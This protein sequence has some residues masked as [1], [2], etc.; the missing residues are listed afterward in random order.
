MTEHT[1]KAAGVNLDAAQDI[2]QRIGAIVTPTHGPEVLGGIGAFGAMYQLSGYK[3]PVLV[4]GTDGVGTKL[5]LAVMMDRYDTIGEDLVNA[6][7]NDVIVSGAKPL[8]FLDYIAVGELSPNVIEALLEGMARACREV[9]CALIGGETAQMP[10]LYAKDDFDM[11]GFVV[12][13]VEKSAM[14][15]SSSIREGDVLLGILSNGLHT[16]GYSLV[17]HTLGLD[18][19]P[20]PLWEHHP[21]LGQTLGDAL[22]TP[23]R[24]YYR[25]VR[26]A[27]SLV[28]GM[29][30]ITGGGLIEN[31]PRVLPEGLAARFDADTWK[32]P[33][34]FTVLQEMSDI[35]RDEMYRV[36]NMG[37]GMVLVCERSKADEV[38]ALVPE[39]RV[40]GEVTRVT[41]ERRVIL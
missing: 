5:K 31:V 32:V 29:A 4:S 20:S 26:P 40:I 28:K 11:A 7:V 6:C 22:L 12:G 17:R 33:P 24:S 23:H 1:Y 34:V 37:M 36:F 13:V 9:D 30:H 35:P 2:K 10:G 8:F 41:D 3:E 15:D 27:F 25:M 14:L 21:E 39:A 19:D 38:A 16:N 18:D